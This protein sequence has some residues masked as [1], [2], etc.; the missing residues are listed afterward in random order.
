MAN[1]AQSA[2]EKGWIEA[3]DRDNKRPGGFVQ[4]S[5]LKRKSHFHDV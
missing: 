4:T 2:F 5:L 3:E 1:F